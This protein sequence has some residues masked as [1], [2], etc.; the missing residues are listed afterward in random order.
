MLQVEAFV[1]GSVTGTLKP[2]PAAC[3]LILATLGVTAESALFVDDQPRN[4]AGARDI[5]MTVLHFDV[6]RP[7]A[8][9]AE[10]ARLLGLGAPPIETRLQARVPHQ[11]RWPLTGRAAT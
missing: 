2:R 3:E 9:Y 4:V 6:T 8:S 7:R 1:D 10:V 5:G 11:E